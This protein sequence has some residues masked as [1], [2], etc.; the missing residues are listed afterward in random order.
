MQNAGQTCISVERVYV[1]APIYDEF[2]DKVTA[3]GRARCARARRRG[4]GTVDVGAITFPPQLDIVEHARRR[5]PRGRA[6]AC[7]PAARRATDGGAFYEPTVLVDVDHSMACMTEETFGPTRAD[8]EGRRRRRG[9]AAGQRLAVRPGRLGVDEG[10]RARRGA[11]APDR[12]RRGLRQRRPAQLRRARAADGRLEG[13]GPRLAPR[14]GRDPQV[15]PPAVAAG[16]ALRAA[17]RTCS[18]TRSRRARRSSSG[19]G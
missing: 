5:R 2:V 13:L 4:P 15:L 6:R 10:R 16:D 1:E 7:S 12:G 19:A 17:A 18:S 8:H 9:G 11:R 3:Q 14:R